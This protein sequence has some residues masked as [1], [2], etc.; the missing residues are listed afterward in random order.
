M[1]KFKL[2][3]QRTWFSSETIINEFNRTYEEII[4]ANSY[5]EDIKQ[6]IVTNKEIG[7]KLGFKLGDKLSYLKGITFFKDN[8]EEQYIELMI[9]DPY[10]KLIDEN[11]KTLSKH[12]CKNH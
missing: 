1:K 4:E 7:E 3:R 12:N 10:Y 6:N 8:N 2:I 5:I 11:G 9:G